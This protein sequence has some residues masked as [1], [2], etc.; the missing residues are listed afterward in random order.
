M[1]TE[2]FDKP[3]KTYE[4]QVDILVNKYGLTV[5]NKNFAVAALQSLTYYDLINGYKEVFMQHDKFAPGTTLET[6]YSM[7]IID[8]NIQSILFEYSSI[9]ENSFKT[10]LAYIIS[11]NFGVSEKNYLKRQ[12]YFLTNDGASFLKL[13]NEFE[14]ILTKGDRM[15]QP[16]KHYHDTHNHIPA[17]ILFK[18][19]TFSNAISLF[20]LLKQNEKAQVT[21]LML[22]ANTLLSYDKQVEFVKNSLNIVRNFRNKIAHNLKF[23]TFKDHVNRLKQQSIIALIPKELMRWKDIK[24]NRRGTEDIYSYIMCILIL[25]N[26]PVLQRIFATSLE[27]S[28]AML[29]SQ[30]NPQRLQAFF[31][32]CEMANIPG[33]FDIRLRNYLNRPKI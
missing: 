12:H 20:K 11:A 7:Y 25:L 19:L 22:P 26:D 23:I 15:P 29:K 1:S 13:E 5:N 8:H 10:K 3:F 2:I 4:E 21:K 28:F 16:T 33:D 27:Q 32:Y 9:I 6:I 31:R 14:N 17:W 24:K 18:N 30:V